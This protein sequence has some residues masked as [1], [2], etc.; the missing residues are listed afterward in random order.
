MKQIKIPRDK[1]CA[2]RLMRNV[3]A[4]AGAL[5]ISAAASAQVTDTVDVTATVGAGVSILNV[6]ETTVGFGT[7]TPAAGASRFESANVTGNYFAANGP[8]EVRLYTTA[9]G[10]EEGLIGTGPNNTGST[11]PFKVDPGADDDVTDN[12][13]WTT[14]FVPVL[15]DG[16]LPAASVASSANGDPADQPSLVFNFGIDAAGSDAGPYSTTVTVEL[17]IL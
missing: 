6:N 3:S 11:L 10:N 4:L 8:W 1:N 9:A 17:A 12:G 13:D 16:S 7:V 2:Q 5:L 14:A 15:D